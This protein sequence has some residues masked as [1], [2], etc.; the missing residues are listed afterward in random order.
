MFTNFVVCILSHR[1][2]SIHFRINTGPVLETVVDLVGRHVLDS[3][4]NALVTLT[5]EAIAR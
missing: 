3:Q 4:Q 2:T 5:R 1:L